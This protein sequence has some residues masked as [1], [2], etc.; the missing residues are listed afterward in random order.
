MIGG[1]V[2]TELEQALELLEKAKEKLGD[3][4]VLLLVESA[5]EELESLQ[6][7]LKENDM[8]EVLDED[9]EIPF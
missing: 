8:A 6:N 5:M 4:E 3:R 1:E 2:M 9:F 7:R